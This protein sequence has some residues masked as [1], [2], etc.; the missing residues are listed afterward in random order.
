MPPDVPAAPDLTSIRGA[1]GQGVPLRVLIEAT[2]DRIDAQS[3]QHPHVFIHR[4]TRE[5]ALQA[6]ATLEARSRAGEA[7]ALLGATFAVK[8]N[9]DVAGMP[10]TAACPAYSYTPERSAP[11]VQRLLDAGAVCVGKT[12]LDQF[13]TGLVGVRSPYGAC[14]NVFDPRYVAGGSSSGSAIAVAA[15]WVSFSLGT[16]TA[17]SGRVPAALGNIVGLKPTPG[18]LSTEGVVPACRSL[19]CVSIFAL[20]CEDARAVYDL[21]AGASAIAPPPTSLGRGFRFGTPSAAHLDFQG[22]AEAARLYTEAIARLTALGGEQVEID[23]TPFHEA[24]AL[25][26][27]GPWVVERFAAVGDFIGRHPNDCLAVT[28]E[29]I[30]GASRY[31][32]VDVFN[33]SYRLAELAARAAAEWQRMDVLL[34]PTVAAVPT[35]EQIAAEPKLRN[36]ALGVYT[37]FTNLLRCAALA[38]PAGFRRDGLPF[39]VSLFAPQG[40]DDRLVALKVYATRPEDCVSLQECLCVRG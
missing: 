34:L 8:D 20:C 33:G 6:A 29:I 18:R 7:L 9:I 40:Q 10:T 14:R 19:D 23:W 2:L 5:Q 4:V 30:A 31:S 17:G 24:G 11:V 1:L 26:Y 3:E 39:G 15:S 38:I 21:A 12:N 27:D 13:A 37:R 32:A 16:D 28:R 35:L 22:D 25:L 36:D